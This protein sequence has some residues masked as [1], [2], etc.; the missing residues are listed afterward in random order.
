MSEIDFPV[1][2]VVFLSSST[3]GSDIDRSISG[4]RRSRSGSDNE[5]DESDTG[6]TRRT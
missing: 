3:A 2:R 6:R 1:S 4:K 5:S